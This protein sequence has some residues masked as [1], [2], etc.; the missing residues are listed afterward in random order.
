MAVV[1]V[2]AFLVEVDLLPLTLMQEDLQVF[3]AHLQPPD[4]NVVYLVDPL[5]LLLE[6]DQLLIDQ[7]L[8][9]S[10][11]YFD[12]LL[13]M[14]HYFLVCLNGLFENLL[15]GVVELIHRCLHLILIN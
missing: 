11:L 2:D 3:V 8:K 1:E 6:R 4:L 14:L 10:L 15:V 5:L 9:A 12:Q 7:F 13:V